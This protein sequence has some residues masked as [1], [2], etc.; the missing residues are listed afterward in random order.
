MV[1]L[2]SVAARFAMESVLD[3][4]SVGTH[5]TLALIT[6]LLCGVL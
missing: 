1:P 4:A 2:D 6:A 3:Y 5:V